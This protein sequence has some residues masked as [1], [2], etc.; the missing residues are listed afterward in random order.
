VTVSFRRLHPLR[1][2]LRRPLRIHLRPSRSRRSGR[3]LVCLHAVVVRPDPDDIRIIQTILNPNTRSLSVSD[4]SSRSTRS[5]RSQSMSF[6]SRARTSS[7]TCFWQRSVHC[8]VGEDHGT[9]ALQEGVHSRLE[10]AEAGRES[11]M[12]CMLSVVQCTYFFAGVGPRRKEG[13]RDRCPTC[14]A[15]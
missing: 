8:M 4:L 10:Q 2:H 15:G 1:R 14:A 11:G 5:P 7:Y 13:E 9:Q 3:A 12:V 6:P